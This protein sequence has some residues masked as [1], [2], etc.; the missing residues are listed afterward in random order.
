[1]SSSTIDNRIVKISLD[2][3]NFEA[4]ADVTLSTLNKLQSALGFVGVA[5]GMTGITGALGKIIKDPNWSAMEALS[6]KAAFSLKDVWIKAVSFLENDVARKLAN[7]AKNITKALTITPVISGFDEYSTQMGAV[8]TIMSNTKAAFTAAGKDQTQQLQEV[9]AA[10][11]ELNLYADKTIYNFT[12][13][14]SNIGRFTAAGVDLDTSVSAIKGISNL[15]AISGSTSQ[16]ASTAMYQLSQALS[17]GTVRLMDWNSVVN[18]NMGGKVFQD[19]LVKTAQQMGIDAQALIDSAG[20]FRDSLSEG[21]LTSEVLTEAL[22]HFSLAVD[23]E[24]E[25]AASR[26]QLAAEGYSQARI[27]EI[28]ELAKDSANAATKVKTVSQLWSTMQEVCS[29]D[30]L[31][32]GNTSLAI[33]RKL[34]KR[35]HLY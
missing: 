18:A 12:E 7:T 31:R 20:S 28:I 14:T 19:E 17:T 6:T 8:Q 2:N 26:A 9:N 16:Q 11:D 25:E 4:N 34:E 35:Y 30:G 15:A 3:K 10:L 13:M 24:A 27:D 1:M 22:N 5:S 21:W 29:L 32:L 33:S 23:T